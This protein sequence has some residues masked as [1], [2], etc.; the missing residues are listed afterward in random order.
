MKIIKNDPIMPKKIIVNKFGGGIMTNEFIPLIKTRLHE[1][2]AAGYCPV[3]VVSALK[4]ITDIILSFFTKPKSNPDKL[5]KNLLQKH[6]AMLT[7][8]RVEERWKKPAKIELAKILADMKKDLTAFNFNKAMA[9]DED[10]ITAYGEK[11]SATV[12]ACYLNAYRLT[13][14]KILAEDIPIITDDNFK[15]ANIDYPI[16]AKNIKKKLL[17]LRSIPVIAGFTGRT[18]SGHTTTIGRGGTDTTACFVGAALRANKVILWKDV[19]GILSADPKI[20]PNATTLP[21]VNYEKAEKIGKVIH[22][23]AI[24]YI[25]LHC[26]PTEI[27]YIVNPKLKTK[28]GP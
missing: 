24:Q 19:A 9:K 21:F 2:V 13:A 15:N 26:T 11:L 4:G 12:L 27:I 10:K 22:P 6:M 5:V 3:I 14:E 18:N 25:K 17:N 7:A 8:A 16:T 23:K 28:I 20:T 1:Q